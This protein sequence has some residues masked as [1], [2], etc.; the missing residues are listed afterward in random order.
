ME[1]TGAV[2][3]VCSQGVRPYGTEVNESTRHLGVAALPADATVTGSLE[4]SFG[5]SVCALAS[6]DADVLV[7]VPG[8]G[9]SGTSLKSRMRLG[10]EGISR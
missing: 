4:Q 2:T 5:R 3:P 8:A 6:G 7:A 1:A 10:T 9:F